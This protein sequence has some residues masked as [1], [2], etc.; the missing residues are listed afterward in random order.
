M[1]VRQRA[2]WICLAIF[3]LTTSALLVFEGVVFLMTHPFSDEGA[4][5]ML[6]PFFLFSGIMFFAA[7]VLFLMF[8][9]NRKG[10][11]VTPDDPK[12]NFSSAFSQLPQGLA[13]IFLGVLLTLP[14]VSIWGPNKHWSL[15]VAAGCSGQETPP[16]SYSELCQNLARF[17]IVAG[18]NT[19]Y[20]FPLDGVTPLGNALAAENLPM[21]FLLLDQGADVNQGKVGGLSPMFE[22]VDDPT[23]FQLF[24]EHG[25]HIEVTDHGGRT[26]L[27]YASAL[28]D[29]QVARELISMGNPLNQSSHTGISPLMAAVMESH[30]DVAG[31]LIRRGA[32]IDARD[33]EGRT[34]LL[35]S[36]N[37]GSVHAVDMLVQLGAD[38]HLVTFDREKSALH[39]AA[40]AGHQDIAK[41]LLQNGARLDAPDVNGVT[42][43]MHAAADGHTAVA[44]Y[45]LGRGAKINLTDNGGWTALHWNAGSEH[46]GPEMSALLMR[47]RAGV[48]ARGVEPARQGDNN[49]L[50]WYQ[51]RKNKSRDWTPLHLAAFKGQDKVV[52]ELLQAGADPNALTA[53]HQTPLSV[54]ARPGGLESVLILLNRGASPNF[55]GQ[56]QSPLHNAAKAGAL[57]V[58]RALVKHGADI[59]AKNN[60][61]MRAWDLAVLN[62]DGHN[63]LA[64]NDLLNP[65]PL[66]K[67]NP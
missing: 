22:V 52:L 57:D 47:Y 33:R 3:F 55:P 39:I 31:E 61:G 66:Q 41:I 58:V 53:N 35:M 6:P 9:E 37:R 1:P 36:V 54:A 17:A 42:A 44:Q 21:V 46:S 29:L 24:V 10:E 34:A 15:S 4:P 27:W 51:S 28:G 43:L 30:W 59:K 5:S 8:F 26:L 38:I 19:G 67:I 56:M 14:V 64:W 62:V 13:A 2:I 25:G 49:H 65:E 32:N 18:G 20:T 12:I 48:H 50:V 60:R 23:L 16:S 45:L 40:E 11:Y 7:G 63:Q